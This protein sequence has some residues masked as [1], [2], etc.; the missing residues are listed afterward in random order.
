[1]MPLLLCMILM[2]K[3]LLDTTVPLGE[4]LDEQLARVREN[5]IIEDEIIDD[6]DDEGSPHAYELFT[7]CASLI[8]FFVA[9]VTSTTK[10][11]NILSLLLPPLPLLS[12]YFA[13]KYFAADT[14][15]SRCG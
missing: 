15:L 13:T 10:T 4:Y 9:T 5:E 12:Y 2:M 1:M 8:Y 11:Q 14:K 6:S 7:Y 3:L